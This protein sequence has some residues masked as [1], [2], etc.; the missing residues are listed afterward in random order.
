MLAT[1]LDRPIS[2][3]VADIKP[4]DSKNCQDD[5]EPAKTTP[6]PAPIQV[7]GVVTTPVT[8]AWAHPKFGSVE[9]RTPT[10]QPAEDS[11][12][13]SVQDLPASI[14]TKDRHP[15]VPARRH[16]L[17]RR[18]LLVSLAAAV[19]LAGG[20]ATTTVFSLGNA[21]PP[22]DEA[23]ASPDGAVTPLW[24]VA[25]TPRDVTLAAHGVLVT[26]GAGKGEVF[27]LT[28]GKPVGTGA[29]P[30]GRPRIV[31]GPDA[32]FVVV[33][34]KDGTNAG[35]VASPSGVKDFAGIKGT[36]VVRGAEPFFLTGSGKHQGALVWDGTTWRPVTVPE[37]GM[38][39]V[40]A[41]KAGVLWLGANGRLVSAEFQRRQ[42]SFR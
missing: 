16:R 1:K 12:G 3:R 11:A 4:D 30:E 23:T 8:Q 37:A 27:S 5:I 15:S 32:V 2:V 9:V 17:G 31:A 13:G 24:Q 40:A 25:V 10:G 7:V 29:L 38:A 36:L 19:L 34:G 26:A 18:T 28:D 42:L 39:P 6:E 33:A 35:F 21:A 41:S 22:T 14:A 20:A